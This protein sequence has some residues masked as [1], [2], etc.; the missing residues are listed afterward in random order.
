MREIH[1][2]IEKNTAAGA[3][4][5]KVVDSG[6]DMLRIM[7]CDDE[8]E[9]ITQLQQILERLSD[10]IRMQKPDAC[11]SPEALL[12]QLERQADKGEALPDVIF[13][14]IRMP[15]L[16]GI[17]F[18]KEVHQITPDIYIIFTTAYEEYA[19]EGY[20]ARAFRYLLK[21]LTEDVVRQTL[22]E[23]QRETG[24]KKKLLIKS[25]DEERIIDLR[26]IVYLS[27][28]DKY[29]ILYMTDGHYL[30]RTSLAE[31]ETALAPFG[32]YRIH[33]KYIVNLYH[34]KS[35]GKSCVGLTGGIRLPLS[36]RRETAY[37]TE[38]FHGLEKELL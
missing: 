12:Q 30:D 19:V 32:F 37:R 33:R 26:D 8:A 24:R 6:A 18:G 35:I 11:T 38:L 28:E 14:D 31:Y 17:A 5:V 9:H 13:L 22:K 27:A 20:A 15:E 4:A 2:E 21:P 16:D 10:G 23:I 36:R 34:H 29:T 7:I 1:K 3:D 25:A